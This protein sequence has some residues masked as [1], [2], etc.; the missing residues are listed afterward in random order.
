[1]M[2]KNE[3]MVELVDVLKSNKLIVVP[4]QLVKEHEKLKAAQLQLIPGVTSYNGVKNLVADGRIRPQETF[5]D[6]GGRTY[7]LR[8]GIERLRGML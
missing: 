7:I 3:F 4:D 6:L 1:M 2:S 5:V 8:S